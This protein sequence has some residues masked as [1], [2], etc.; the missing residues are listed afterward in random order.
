[1]YWKDSSNV[2]NYLTFEKELMEIYI[3]SNHLSKGI[4]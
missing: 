3:E 1:M 4:I 2:E